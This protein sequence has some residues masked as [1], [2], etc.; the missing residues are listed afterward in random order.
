MTSV[1]EN[2]G[3]TFGESPV[4]LV[5]EISE[6]E[7]STEL[8]G[9]SPLREGDPFLESDSD[10]DDEQVLRNPKRARNEW[11]RNHP[12]RR[13][14]YYSSTSSSDIDSISNPQRRRLQRRVNPSSSSNHEMDS[15]GGLG[16][17]SGYN[18][19]SS[20]DTST[21]SL[22][23][24]NIEAFPI[25]GSMNLADFDVYEL[26]QGEGN[27]LH[28]ILLH[29]AI[30]CPGLRDPLTD[31]RSMTETQQFEQYSYMVSSAWADWVLCCPEPSVSD[32][33]VTNVSRAFRQERPFMSSMRWQ[34]FDTSNLNE[35][36]LFDHFLKY[37]RKCSSFL[38]VKV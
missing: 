22:A 13:T 2:D 16:V 10:S 6:S 3:A 17:A 37:K 8:N 9:H 25:F 23:S 1:V 11:R 14:K 18:H 21:S 4:D 32:E 38:M 20:T 5:I 36:E 26:S 35:Q 24:D 27:L 15:V 7:R 19:G 28:A 34:D 33:I 31:W 12:R 30:V 29:L